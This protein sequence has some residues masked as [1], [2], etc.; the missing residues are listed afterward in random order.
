MSCS[1]IL[2]SSTVLLWRFAV[3]TAKENVKCRTEINLSVLCC[4]KAVFGLGTS[5][6]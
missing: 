6:N 4:K 5:L 2:W 3:K 1:V